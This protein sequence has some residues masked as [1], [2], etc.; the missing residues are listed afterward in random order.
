MNQSFTKNGVVQ[1]FQISAKNGQVQILQIS[2]K[3]NPFA[4]S[5]LVSDTL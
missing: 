4:T 1:I 3:Q 5:L 2:A